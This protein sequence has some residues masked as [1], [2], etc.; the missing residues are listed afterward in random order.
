MRLRG[1]F[2]RAASRLRHTRLRS[3][4]SRSNKWCDS[5]R[6]SLEK[7]DKTLANVQQ[8]S[9]KINTGQGTIGHLVNDDKLGKNLDKAATALTDLFGSASQL[10]IEIQERSEFLIGNPIRNGKPPC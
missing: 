1:F 2:R 7:L 9:E 10:R 5:L 6:S 3:Y 4:D 8:I